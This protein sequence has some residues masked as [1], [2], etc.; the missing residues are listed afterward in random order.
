MAFQELWRSRPDM[1]PG[2][3]IVITVVGRIPA[4]SW[5]TDM[6]AEGV[7]WTT[8]LGGT[9]TRTDFAEPI[10]VHRETNQHWNAAYGLVTVTMV[11][12]KLF[13]STLGPSA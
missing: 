4:T 12:D 1:S 8:L 6:P 2:D 10:L 5:L 3:K 11:G 9:W 13:T 7:K